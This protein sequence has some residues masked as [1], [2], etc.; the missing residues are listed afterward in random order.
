MD[1]FTIAVL[2]AVILILVIFIWISDVAGI[3]LMLG[4]LLLSDKQ[5]KQGGADKLDIL[6]TCHNDPD[7]PHWWIDVAG[8]MKP[9]LEYKD[10]EF[11]EEKGIDENKYEFYYSDITRNDTA[12]EGK[13]YKGNLFPIFDPDLI[14]TDKRDKGQPST[15]SQ[16]I[17]GDVL[18]QIGGKKFDAVLL[19]DCGGNAFRYNGYGD[20]KELDDNYKANFRLFLL[21]MLALV[22]VGGRLVIAKIATNKLREVVDLIKT[23]LEDTYPIKS[24]EIDGSCMIFIFKNQE[25]PDKYKYKSTEI[26]KYIIGQYESFVKGYYN[27]IFL[28]V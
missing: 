22:K 21:R 24:L 27:D 15:I 20:S 16:I 17:L 10:G 11:K 7:K 9:V 2:V 8:Y 25:M 19:P 14:T 5:N 26:S 6:I 3:V 4:L 18:T 13:Y 28:R 23:Y 12:P 1:N